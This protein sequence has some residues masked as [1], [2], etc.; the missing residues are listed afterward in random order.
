MIVR[1]HRQAGSPADQVVTRTF[2]RH[3][4]PASGDETWTPFTFTIAEGHTDSNET[5]TLIS[6]STADRASTA[7]DDLL[8]IDLVAVFGDGGEVGKAKLTAHLDAAS[9]QKAGNV[10][11]VKGKDKNGADKNYTV[12]VGDTQAELQQGL[13]T[14]GCIVLYDGHSNEGIGPQFI[15]NANVSRLSDL[16]NVGN[17]QAAINLRYWKQVC[18]NFTLPDAEAAGNVTN[19]DV[20][21]FDAPSKLR[22]PNSDGVGAG[23]VFQRS[24]TGLDR[25]HYGN[26]NPKNYYLIVK[27]E[28]ADLPALNYDTFFFNECDSGRD[29]MEVFNRGRLLYTNSLVDINSPTSKVFVENVINGKSWADVLAA[30]NQVENLHKQINR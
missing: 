4:K 23:G 8:P 20:P 14:P 2:I 9:T 30:L 27:A 18:P 3:T 24:G 29:F 12:L 7:V 17:P 25:N 21:N 11:I 22:Y 15:P 13:S 28:A 19:Y 1:L 5:V 26:G 10:Y 6:I 16:M